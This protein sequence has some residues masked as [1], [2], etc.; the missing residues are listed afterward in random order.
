[1]AGVREI[2]V[3]IETAATSQ[4]EFE[5]LYRPL[6]DF[7][8]T[9]PVPILIDR[10]SIQ[11]DW[12]PKKPSH[13]QD[14]FYRLPRIVAARNQVCEFVWS[15]SLAT[16]LLFIDSDVKPAP[17]GLLH[18][19]PLRRPLCGGLGT[20]RG[21][22]ERFPMIFGEISRAGSRSE[23]VQC[24]WGTC[25]YMLIEKQ[26]L[27]VQRFR[28][29]T[30]AGFATANELRSEDPAFCEDAWLNGFGRFWIHTQATATHHDD[31]VS[32]LQRND[33]PEF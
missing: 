12:M 3:N 24:Q 6:L 25:G 22:W 7:A 14:Q 28:W 13:D 15:H 30:S 16:H 21:P 32:P 2:V 20:G 1:M 5:S 17:D 9:S 33:R 23:L 26:V 29:G 31:P 4:L 19:L 10:W 18:L 27:A 11:S 8:K